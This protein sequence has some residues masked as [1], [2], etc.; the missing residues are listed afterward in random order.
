MKTHTQL[1][2]L[3]YCVTKLEVI[4]SSLHFYHSMSSVKNGI[5]VT[6]KHYYFQYYYQTTD[7]HYICKL[8]FTVNRVN[9]IQVTSAGC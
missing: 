7:V 2:Y 6:I 4:W 3:I 8:H 9:L 1:N 5:Y